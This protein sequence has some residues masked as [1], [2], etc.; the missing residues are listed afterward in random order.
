MENNGVYVM[1]ETGEDDFYERQTTLLAVCPNSIGKVWEFSL[2]QSTFVTTVTCR[3]C[4]L[5]L[6]L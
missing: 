1:K 4:I 6:L 2:L 5:R 3:L